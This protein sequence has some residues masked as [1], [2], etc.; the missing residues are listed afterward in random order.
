MNY[1]LRADTIR[2]N[3]TYKFSYLLKGFLFTRTFRPIITLRLCQ[4][5]GGRRL[6]LPVHL[7][8]RMLHRY[9]CSKAGI[10]LS[11]KTSIGYGF[12]L[13]HGWGTVISP[14]AN[15]GNNVTIFNGALIGAH[16]KTIE[17]KQ[18]IKSPKIEDQVWIGA[19]AVVVGDVVVGK[20]SRIL[21]GSFV[22]E[23]IPPGSVVKGN[24]SKIIRGNCTADCF[25]RVD[26]KALR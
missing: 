25:N 4:S 1:A 21:A 10:D 22:A 8:C 11:W 23:S 2:V 20:G 26:E 15:I 9:A 24:P 19:N 17:G 18:V 14:H 6:Y 5:S 13:T 12:I 7:I 3:G 16:I